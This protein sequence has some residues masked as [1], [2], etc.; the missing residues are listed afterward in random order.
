MYQ[1][2]ATSFAC[3]PRCKTVIGLQ[4]QHLW[5][6]KQRINKVL[7]DVKFIITF[8]DAVIFPEN[9]SVTSKLC[10]GSLSLTRPACRAKRPLKIR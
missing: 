4:N 7:P 6:E 5:S 1:H 3:L 2:C 10:R 8:D 9:Q